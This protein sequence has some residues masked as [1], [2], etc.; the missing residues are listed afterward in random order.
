VA[1]P[2]ELINH[3]ACCL[4]PYM[5]ERLAALTREEVV[6]E[7]K[8]GASFSFP[9]TTILV[10]QTRVLTLLGRAYEGLFAAS[11]GFWVW[12]G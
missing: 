3:C 12:R 4:L 10:Q 7:P 9:A 5:A 1:K 8:P 2:T 11:E 6:A